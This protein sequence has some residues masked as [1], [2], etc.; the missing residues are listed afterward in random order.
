M[1]L[2]PPPLT[3][4]GTNSTVTPGLRTAG[5]VVSS[6][7]VGIPFIISTVIGCLCF[8]CTSDC[9][10]KIINRLDEVQKWIAK[11]KG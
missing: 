4:P 8:C 9:T 2:L 5:V 1:L 11:R 6:V 3:P 7:G 10:R